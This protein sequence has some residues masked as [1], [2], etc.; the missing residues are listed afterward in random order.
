MANSQVDEFSPIVKRC[1]KGLPVNVAGSVKSD[2]SAV[3]SWIM[4]GTIKSSTPVRSA[5]AQKSLPRLDKV[6]DSAVSDRSCEAGAVIVNLDA[7]GSTSELSQPSSNQDEF[8]STKS[9]YLENVNSY[10][11][12]LVRDGAT[13]NESKVEGE[14]AVDVDSMESNSSSTTAAS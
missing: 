13:V 6:N 1:K 10:C 9:W 11:E 2:Q 3:V 12:S 8:D 7:K 14:A 4:T 5:E